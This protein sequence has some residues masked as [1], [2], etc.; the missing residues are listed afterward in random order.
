M[1][2]QM[3][4]L[5]R[6][7]VVFALVGWLP[8]LV[9]TILSG[10][11]V[12]GTGVPFLFAVDAHLRCLL[13]VPLLLAAEVIAHRRIQ[14]IVGQF[15]SRGV[16]APEDQPPL[17]AAM[18]SAMRLRD[19]TLPEVLVLGLS[20]V[21]ADV[22]WR[23]HFA[24]N[25]AT[26]IA[27]PVDGRMQFTP[28]GNYYFFV[29][30]MIQRFL[31]LRW[32]FRLFVWH[33][34]LWQVSRH[35]PLR[36]DAL[37]PDRAGGLGFLGDS[38]LAFAPVLF[39]QTLALAGAIGAKIWREGATLPQ[40]KI[41]IAAWMVFLGLQVLTPLCFF[42]IQMSAARRAGGRQYG[43]VASRYVADFRRK[44]IEGD[45]A[46]GEALVGSAD[47]QSLADLANSFDVTREMRVVPFGRSTLVQLAIVMALP[48]LPLTLTMIPLDELIDRAIGVFF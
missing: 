35:V 7:I 28:G 3:D 16:I 13:F 12:S 8:L 15:M 30:L 47:I 20:Y 18:A 29:S 6:R 36:L 46:E 10:D 14:T 4:L 2:P 25:V 22:L 9:L 38:V 44:W 17:K 41:E 5:G 37:H 33:R 24:L 19:S 26:W 34:F 27:A 32:Y 45:V 39:A 31:C 23:G 43:I 11:A 42:V 21:G 48:L 40:F 1:G